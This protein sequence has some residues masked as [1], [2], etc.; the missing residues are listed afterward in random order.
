MCRL[1]ASIVIMRLLLIAPAAGATFLRC[2]LSPI[3][4]SI[5]A[6]C[7]TWAL[8]RSLITAVVTLSKQFLN[9]SA[10]NRLGSHPQCRLLLFKLFN[11]FVG[12][13]YDLPIEIDLRIKIALAFS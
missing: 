10:T 7:H 11:L 4:L 2:V 5:H 1:V 12:L 6:G 3:R 8:Q 9:A 13:G